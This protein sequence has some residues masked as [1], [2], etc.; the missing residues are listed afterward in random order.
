[1]YGLSCDLHGS[2]NLFLWAYVT[3]EDLGDLVPAGLDGAAD[4]VDL[5]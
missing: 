2:D 5:L 1:M 3:V 4:P